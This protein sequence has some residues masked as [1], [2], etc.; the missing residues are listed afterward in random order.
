MKLTIS[1]L[2]ITI[3]LAGY[4]LVSA[5][6]HAAKDEIITCNAASDKVKNGAILIDVRTVEEFTGGSLSGAI[7]I[8]LH[9]IESRLNEFPK[10]KTSTIVLYC[11]SGRRAASA[12][13][14]L[15]KNGYLNIYNAGGFSDLNKCW[16]KSGKQAK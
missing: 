6:R 14:I 11:K 15:Q 10:D 9:L 4:F 16:P 12:K 5:N 1:I 8:P 3:I 13:A 7:N 2:V